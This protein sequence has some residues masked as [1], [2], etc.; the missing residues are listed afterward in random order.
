MT[1]LRSILLVEDNPDDEVLT[2]RALRRNN[3]QNE[4]MV[5]RSGQEALDVLNQSTVLPCV[6]LL[7]LKLPK[8]PGLE[9]LRRI[10]ANDR[11]RSLPVVLLTSSKEE[12][13]IAEGY[14]LGANSYVCKPVDFQQFTAAVSQLGL[15]WAVINEPLV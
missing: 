4:I 3:L 13:D 11:W 1:S 12:R 14:E 8:I 15:Y 10:R 9:V 5:A 6:V 2:L 7:D